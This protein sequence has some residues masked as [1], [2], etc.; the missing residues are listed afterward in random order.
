MKTVLQCTSC[1]QSKAASSQHCRLAN[2]PKIYHSISA[3]DVAGTFSCLQNLQLGCLCDLEDVPTAIQQLTAA[4]HLT[5]L[6]LERIDGITMRA[7]QHVLR[8]CRN[9]SKLRVR[10]C[11]GLSQDDMERLAAHAAELCRSSASLYWAGSSMPDTDDEEGGDR[12][13]FE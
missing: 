6:V 11:D 12:L 4:Q 2:C 13:L 3:P 8:G 7:L 5:S 9:L 1:S 10:G